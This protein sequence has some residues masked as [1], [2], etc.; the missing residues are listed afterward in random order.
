LVSFESNFGALDGVPYHLNLATLSC[1]AGAV[2]T[3]YALGR[4]S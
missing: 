4:L 2:L 3:R 1:A